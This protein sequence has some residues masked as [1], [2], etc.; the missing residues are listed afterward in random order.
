MSVEGVV[1]SPYKT[2]QVRRKVPTPFTRPS[3]TVGGGAAGA[4]K[5]HW[6][7]I[8]VTDVKQGD[9]V[10]N[11]G[12]V[13]EIEEHVRIR[14]WINGRPWTVELHNVMGETKVYGGE[15]VVLAFV[16]QRP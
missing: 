3:I 2:P 6:Q 7:E 15:D 9:T 1:G 12:V 8:A 13:D 5:R 14:E 11:F 4:V 10:A 16:A